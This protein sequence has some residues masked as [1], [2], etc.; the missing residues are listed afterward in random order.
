MIVKDLLEKYPVTP[1]GL[2]QA[3]FHTRAFLTYCAC[4]GDPVKT[5]IAHGVTVAA[6][7][8][9][10]EVY[11]WDKRLASV[12]SLARS[13]RPGDMERAVNRAINFVQAQQLRTVIDR[14]VEYLFGMK[15]EDVVEGSTPTKGLSAGRMQW[16]GMADLATALE[17]CHAMTYAALG[18][19]MGERARM[20]MLPTGK[21]GDKPSEIFASMAE[22]ALNMVKPDFR[23]KTLLREAQE[24]KVKQLSKIPASERV[25]E[26]ASLRL[27]IGQQS[28]SLRAEPERVVARDRSEPPDGPES[29][30]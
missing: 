9:C 6:I 8:E 4:S 15:T 23:P 29:T 3:P 28:T 24:D 13:D 27:P 20:P 21:A 26:A 22:Q 1:P 11:E 14:C 2:P 16:R 12:L 5:S 10:A 18:D 19:T 17:K 30:D 7:E 25:S